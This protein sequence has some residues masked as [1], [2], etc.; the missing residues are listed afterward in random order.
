[1]DNDTVSLHPIKFLDRTF[2]LI[3][4]V[5]DRVDCEDILISRQSNPPT[6]FKILVI[7]EKKRIKHTNLL[8]DAR[9]VQDCCP[10]RIRD[11]WCQDAR[12]DFLTQRRKRAEAQPD[13]IP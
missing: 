10:T 6:E 2:E 7:Q 12:R 9:A 13:P 8:Q 1:M 11:L 4:V 5:R 3:V